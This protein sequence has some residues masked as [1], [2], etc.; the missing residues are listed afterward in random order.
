MHREQMMKTAG[1]YRWWVAGMAF[2]VQMMAVTG[3]GEEVGVGRGAVYEDV[4]LEIMLPAN[5]RADGGG[6][7]HERGHRDDHLGTVWAASLEGNTLDGFVDDLISRDVHVVH[8]APVTVADHEAVELIS[9]STYHVYELYVRRGDE[10]IVISFRT[11]PD[12]FADQLEG[13]RAAG[14]SIRFAR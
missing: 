13:F 4:G 5:W 12:A 14:R 9:E 6:M 7:H 2:F 11:L 10:V 8:R 1:P 3:C